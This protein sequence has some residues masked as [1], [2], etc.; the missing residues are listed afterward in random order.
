M[1]YRA[2]S[3]PRSRH[4]GFEGPIHVRSR[5]ARVDGR[6]R[7]SR[8]G[9]PDATRVAPRRS[10]VQKDLR[11]RAPRPRRPGLHAGVARRGFS[12]LAGK[13]LDDHARTA[14]V[15]EAEVP[16]VGTFQPRHRA[17]RAPRPRRRDSP[18]ERVGGDSSAGSC[19]Y[20]LHPRD[21]SRPWGARVFDLLVVARKI[22][23]IVCFDRLLGLVL[24]R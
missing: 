6:D 23:F 19:R 15:S 2:G 8:Q 3:H 5:W 16:R 20:P 22:P 17:R 12:R 1:S 7:S 24:F 14:P 11:D 13:P 4:R 10:R 9:Y 18:A 21:F